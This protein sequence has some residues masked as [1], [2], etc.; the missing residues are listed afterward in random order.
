MPR[1]FISLNWLLIGSFAAAAVAVDVHENVHDYV[2]DV[3]D[4]DLNDVNYYYYY[5]YY[6]QLHLNLKSVDDAYE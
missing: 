4:D 2:N 3:N 1:I 6:L 5:Y